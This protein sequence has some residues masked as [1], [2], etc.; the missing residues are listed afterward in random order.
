MKLLRAVEKGRY[1]NKQI[2][3]EE[4]EYYHELLKRALHLFQNIC[5][6]Y[7]AER[8]FV[9]TSLTFKYTSLLNSHSN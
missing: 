4:Y 3:R 2:Q 7:R 1:N 6:C 5:R 8:T 9:Y